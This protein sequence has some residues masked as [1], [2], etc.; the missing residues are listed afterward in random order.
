MDTCNGGVFSTYSR[1]GGLS[2]THCVVCDVLYVRYVTRYVNFL[3]VVPRS[4]QKH[5]NEKKNTTAVFVIMAF[6]KKVLSSVAK[7]A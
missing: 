7:L 1:V 3:F 6:I 2:D 4:M 5:A